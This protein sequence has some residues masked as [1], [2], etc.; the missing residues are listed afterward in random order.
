MMRKR[1]QAGLCPRS[2]LPPLLV[3][4]MK[5]FGLG[6]RF[7][8]SSVVG[9][10]AQLYDPCQ[11][12]A[13]SCGAASASLT[14]TFRSKKSE[15]AASL[16]WASALGRQK[17]SLGF[18]SDVAKNE[19]LSARTQQVLIKLAT[20]WAEYVLD[21][22][23]QSQY[24]IK[25]ALLAISVRAKLWPVPI[26]WLLDSSEQIASSSPCQWFDL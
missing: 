4:S 15:N 6:I 12:G 18:P 17:N 13:V 14:S 25:G 26:N 22:A 11:I 23:C 19:F 24:I 10:R 2:T 5:C 21:P 1:D 20:L 3:W 16:E 8:H 9:E 7:F